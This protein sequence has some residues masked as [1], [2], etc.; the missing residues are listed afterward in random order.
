MWTPSTGAFSED[1]WLQIS[2]SGIFPG[3]KFPNLVYTELVFMDAVLQRLPTTV[4]RN[5]E[6]ARVLLV[7]DDVR[8]RLTLKA[9]L[10]AGGYSVDAASSAAEAFGKLDAQQYALVMSEL[11]TD[12][13]KA[14]LAVL[15]HARLMHYQPATAIL[16]TYQTKQPDAQ[17]PVLIRPEE[18]PELLGK[19]ADLI[20]Q[21]AARLVALQLGEGSR[22][23]VSSD[24]LD[25]SLVRV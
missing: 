15:A 23:T 17:L 18:L 12:A 13:P 3:T 6:V 1:N 21:R 5:L 24:P 4:R 25:G 22:R 14:G 10:E 9:V 8:S 11:Q 19:V 20:S 2:I 7:D 16:T